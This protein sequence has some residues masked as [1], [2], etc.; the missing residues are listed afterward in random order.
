MNIAI[1]GFGRIGRTFFRQAYGKKGITIVGINDLGEIYN[2]AY[3]LKYDSVYRTYEQSVSVKGDMLVVGKQKIAVLHE[4]EPEKLP[5]KQLGVD[6]VIESTGVFMTQDEASAHTRAGAKRVVISAPA[7]DD[8]PTATPN[9]NFQALSRSN[10]SSN[11]SCTTNATNPIVAVLMKELGIE[12][13]MLTTVHGYTATQKIVDGPDAK[14]F[15]RGR[16]G[17]MN[18]IPTSTGAAE[19]V[20]HVLPE[21]K[22]KFD[23]IAMRVPVAT[24]SII[25]FTFLSRRTTTVAEVNAILSKAAASREWSGILTVAEQP[26][27]SSDIIGSPFGS[28]VDLSLTRV[29]DGNM[30]KVCA[31][32][33]N[34]W[35]YCAMLIKHVESLAQFLK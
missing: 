30:V 15:A 3:L 7:R 18:I 29:V 27:V 14:D 4:K 21:V 5:W 11:A 24:G 2:L 33:D 6:V 16:A 13:G 8:T 10:I 28:I 26:L 25:D 34:E 17:A 19:A 1:N 32:Y 23:G 20:E 22:G 12:K 35:G 9:L 31:W